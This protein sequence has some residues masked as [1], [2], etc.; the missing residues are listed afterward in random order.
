MVLLSAAIVFAGLGFISLSDSGDGSSA[1]AA[2]PSSSAQTTS[3][4]SASGSGE[5]AAA[6]GA[7]S[8]AA[9]STTSASSSS[10][11]SADPSDA[12]SGASLPEVQ[13]GQAPIRVYNNSTVNG[14]ASDTAS[15][16]ET[17]GWSIGEV[18]N[19]DGGAVPRSAVY[20][21]DDPG[22]KAAAEKIGEELGFP[23][24]PR[25]DGID[26][27]SPGVIVILTADQ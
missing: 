1:S 7:S 14:L 16:L 12:R 24:E 25:F 22:S 3:A 23:V 6:A 18:A 13:A 21:G 15:T 27:A 9:P 19:Y 20:Y 2:E 5:S 8:A 26:D 11:R 17:D 4:G 10:T